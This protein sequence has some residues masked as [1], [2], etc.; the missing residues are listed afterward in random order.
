MIQLNLNRE[1]TKALSILC[2][3]AHSDDIEIG[4]G[5]TILRL[6][7][8]YPGTVFHWVVFSANGVREA[9]AQRAAAL[10]VD[11]AHL[12]GPLVKTFPDGFMPF[13]GAD[14]KAMFEELK[15]TVSPD[16]IFTHN[17]KDAHQDH[18]LIA[19]LTWNTFRDHLILEYEIPKYDGDLG[20]PNVFVP[21]EPE[22]LQRKVRYLMDAFQSQHTKH[23]FREDI[24][25]SL[26][27]LRGMECNARSGYA[28]AFYCRKLVLEPRG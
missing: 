14:I 17:R 16:L 12:R 15:L 9:E 24:F 4:C 10:F 19:E 7:E 6:A 27:Q 5:G 23:W 25:R 2:L 26:M 11:P 20:Q 22:L 1:A 21:L 28:E 13:V 18:R 3:G 8:Q